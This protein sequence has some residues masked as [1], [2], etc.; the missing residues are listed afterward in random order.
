MAV[1]LLAFYREHEVSSDSLSSLSAA[2]CQWPA[3]K[4]N[5]RGAFCSPERWPFAS[6]NV[7]FRN[8]QSKMI[9]FQNP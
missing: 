3:G 6:A 8:S 7:P 1:N 5:V 9:L 4:A 2:R